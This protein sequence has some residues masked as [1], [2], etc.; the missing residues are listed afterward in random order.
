MLRVSIVRS[1]QV[2]PMRFTPIAVLCSEGLDIGLGLTDG[3]I[4]SRQ[5]DARSGKQGWDR[6]EERHTSQD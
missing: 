4:H 2:H 6:Q 5:L 3:R 1:S